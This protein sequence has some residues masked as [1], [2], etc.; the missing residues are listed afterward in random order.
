MLTS[1]F[2]NTLSRD[3]E[4][5]LYSLK[6]TGHPLEEYCRSCA[7]SFKLLPQ[8][9]SEQVQTI[10]ADDLDILFIAT[11]VTAVTNQICLLA[12]HRLARIQVTSGGSVVTT[13]MRHMDYYISGTLTD[14]SPTAPEH[15][16]EKLVKLEGTAH[17][18]SYGCESEKA[19]AE[20][21]RESLGISEEAVIFISGA[22][23]FKIVPELIHT[24]AKIIAEVPNSVLVL[25]PF[26]PNW[27]NSYP[28]KAFENNLNKVFSQYEISTERLLI[29]DPQPVPNREDVKEYFKIADLYLDSYPFSGTTSLIEPLQVNLPVISRQ[30]QTFRSAMGAAM[31]RSL[32]LPDLVAD[33]EETYIQL[34][35]KLGTNP[36]LR[37]QKSDRIFQKMQQN[38]SFL[39]SRS[40]SAQMGALFQQFFQQDRANNLIDRLGLRDINLV[41]FPDWHQSEESLYEDFANVLKTMSS[42]PDRSR[43]TLL[44]DTDGIDGED[45]N[46][47][48]SSV[49]M[50]LLM[51][52]A[53]DIADDLEVSLLDDLTESEW[54]LLLS[55][56]QGRIGLDNENPNAIAKAKAQSLK[57]YS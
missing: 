21:E 36:E 54:E 30:G 13:G 9:L 29:L 27:S 52:E 15:Y 57:V 56:M 1:L 28:K 5:V 34:A 41:M 17:C 7:N 16:R 14:P 37:K 19:T 23:F 53:V 2:T 31:V 51:E 4:V 46:W 55:L 20:V 44:I 38:P 35:V 50:N 49:A 12:S 43:M 24:W 42:N 22:N 32:D 40:Y 10:R 39:D 45:A 47:L 6:Q 26:G 8:N 18:F 48:F 25:L 33:S 3:F 11:N